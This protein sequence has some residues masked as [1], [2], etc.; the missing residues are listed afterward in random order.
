MFNAP[1]P[2][3]HNLL[4]NLAFLTSKPTGHTTYALNLLPQL[5][6]LSPT[7]LSP[8]SIE[9]Y[10]CHIIPDNINTDHGS[11]GHLRRLIWTQWQLP[12][13]YKELKSQLIF[14]PV[15]EAPLFSHCRY[16]VTVHDLIPLRFA[17]RFSRLTAYFRYYIPQ[18]LRQAEHIICNSQSTANEVMEFFAIPAAKITPILLAYDA[19][20]F[21]NLDLPTQNYFL[22]LG[23]HDHYKNLHRLL[24]A[25]ASLPKHLWQ[26]QELQLWLAG[27]KDQRYTPLLQ[28]QVIELGLEQRVKFLDYVPYADL[29]ALINQAIALVFPSLWEGFGL[30]ALEALACG[31]P[32][33]ASNLSALPEVTGDAAILIAPY[34]VEAIAHAMQEVASSELVRSQ[35]RQAG[36]TRAQQFSW[37]ATGKATAAVLDQYS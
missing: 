12:K 4:V 28:A 23:R 30:P 26:D 29:P 11:K 21:H 37:E 22:Y 17:R 16:V 2:T 3:P 9:P 20:H 18:V 35:L 32:V 10:S 27:P 34:N 14:S 19:S 6:C 1:R 31:T 7:L 24:T 8:R 36:L 5:Q 33:I 15:P 25:F 13:I